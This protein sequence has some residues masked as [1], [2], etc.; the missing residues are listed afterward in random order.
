MIDEELGRT[1]CKFRFSRGCRP[2]RY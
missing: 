2:L 1:V